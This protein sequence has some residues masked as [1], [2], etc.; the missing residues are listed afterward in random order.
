[1]RVL[2]SDLRLLPDPRPPLHGPL[3]EGLRHEQEWPQT[4]CVTSLIL[5]A[6]FERDLCLPEGVGQR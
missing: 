4:S 1:M 6:P 5:G 3:T 2:G